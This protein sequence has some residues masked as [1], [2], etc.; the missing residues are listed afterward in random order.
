MK[1]T[2]YNSRLVI[3][4]VILQ[5]LV[6]NSGCKKYLSEKQDQK[7]STISTIQDLQALMDDNQ[8]ISQRNLKA[9]EASAD[10]Y[11]LTD[12]TVASLPEYD[13]RIY[14]WDK[15]RL[16]APGSNNDWSFAYSNVYVANIVLA[17]I[18]KIARTPNDELAWGSAKGQALFLRGQA[19]LQVATLWAKVYDSNNAD[20]IPG[21]PLRLDPDFNK[22]S[23][24]ANLKVTFEQIVNDLKAAAEVLP[25]TAVHVLRPSKAAVYGLLARTYLYMRDY[26]NAGLYARLSLQQKSDLK[27]YKTLNV[28]QTP[29]YPFAPRFSNPEILVESTI[30]APQVIAFTTAKI[31]LQLYQSYADNDLRKKA[32][33]KSNTD[34]SYAFRGSYSGANMLFS[35]VATDEMYLISAEAYARAG[36]TQPAMDE[37]NKLLKTRY[38]ATFVPL[39]A[40]SPT[41]ALA[42]IL[43]ER[44]KELLMRGLRWMDIKRLNKEGASITLKRTNNGQIYTL[45]PNDNRF[46]LPIPEDVIAQTGMPQNER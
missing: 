12:A 19:F 8:N 32:F 36:E 43:T 4:F 11:Y 41:Y 9:A 22:P 5:G 20:E 18:D 17:N 24:R 14:L 2:K 16:F 46:A 6:L 21:I 31:D 44:R 3:L 13:R 27:D 34:N 28:A 23:T 38:D 7:L 39:T 30:P 40:S 37:L 29:V 26:V 42:I 15:E 35:G 25:V 10:D 1:T 33:F 45:P